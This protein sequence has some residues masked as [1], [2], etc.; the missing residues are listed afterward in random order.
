MTGLVKTVDCS[1]AH[2]WPNL[3]P[4]HSALQQLLVFI[5]SLRTCVQCI[6]PQSALTC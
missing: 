6:T 4:D 1:E 2:G 3:G 5:A